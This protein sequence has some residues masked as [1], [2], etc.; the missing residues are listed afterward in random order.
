MI[1]PELNML[2]KNIQQALKAEDLFGVPQTVSLDDKENLL[3]II[4]DIYHR[5][6]R[7]CHPDKF[8]QEESKDVAHDAFTALN[9]LYN[10]AK[11]KIRQGTYGKG[12]SDEVFD[13]SEYLI[14]TSKRRYCIESTL[15]QGDLATVYGG[16]CPGAGEEDMKIAIKV[17]E[18]PADND[19]MQNEIRILKLLHQE[20]SVYSKHLPVLIDQFKTSEGQMGMIMKRLDA[21][22]LYTIREKYKSGIPSHH[23]IWI[24]RRILSILGFAHIK[25]IIHGNV[26]PSHIMV[27]PRDH[28][29]YLVDW[30]Y[31]IYKPGTTGQGFKALNEDYSPPEVSA[32][33]PPIPA[34]DMYSLAKC[35]VYLL[36]GNI[37]DHSIP[38]AVDDRIK[39]FIQFFL[40]DSA[41]QRPQDAWDM[42]RKLD[43]LR[44]DVF[45]PHRF[46]EFV[47]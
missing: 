24:F 30:S 2:Y 23:I 17:I 40:R 45:G 13:Q 42:Y 15:A 14:D 41:I 10:N 25:G 20:A 22:D 46:R 11:K 27:R 35:M 19:L 37:H 44:E 12:Y 26:E 4:K 32:G 36:G 3:E 39:R 43:E 38:D 8:S 9:E 34:S 33:K 31:S 5:F 21:Y 6:A 29:V 16:T 18:D 47:M 28:N 1:D 7:I